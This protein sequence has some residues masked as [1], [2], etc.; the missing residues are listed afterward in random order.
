MMYGK[1]SW[2]GVGSIHRITDTM[3]ALRH[4]DIL[5]SAMFPYALYEN[6]D[7]FGSVMLPYASQNMPL[8]W[9]FQQDND[10]KPTPS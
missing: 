2:N 9:S 1:F 5:E 3:T 4:K 10:P 7:I 6:M 8:I